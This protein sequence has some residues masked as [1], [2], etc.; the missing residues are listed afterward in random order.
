MF[1]SYTSRCSISSTGQ[2][3]VIRPT[4]VGGLSIATFIVFS[5]MA[6]ALTTT[7][8]DSDH[9][10]IPM[11][12]ALVFA[13]LSGY[14]ATSFLEESGEKLGV[15]LQWARKSHRVV[16]YILYSIS[17]SALGC[18]NDQLRALVGDFSKQTFTGEIQREFVAVGHVPSHLGC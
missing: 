8:L 3:L 4:I 9:V 11:V 1:Q 14:P 15:L 12:A 6:L 13:L 16:L 17:E 18:Q 2:D 7:P 5:M 10:I